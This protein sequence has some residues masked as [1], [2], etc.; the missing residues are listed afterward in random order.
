MHRALV[1]IV[2]FLG[3]AARVDARDPDLVID[4]PQ[5][6]NY[7]YI[8]E[9]YFSPDD[10][11]VEEQCVAG[12]GVRKLLR[13]RT[14]S[15]N[16]GRVDLVMGAPEGNPLF[17][18]SAC[19]GH[20]HFSDY[21]DYRLK[22]SMG[23]V[24]APGHKQAFCLE[25][26]FQYLFDPWVG[27]VRLYACDS[28]GIQAGWSDVYGADLDCQWVDVTGVPNGTYFL[29]V[30]VNPSQVLVEEDLTNNIA[31]VQ[32]QITDVVGVSHRPDGWI[33]PGTQLRVGRN[34]D[35]DRL[36]Y[37]VATCPAQ[38]YVALYSTGPVSA[39][40]Y[41]GA[42]CALGLA[43]DTSV[44]IPDP[45]PGELV[46]L[47]VVGV[48]SSVLPGAEGGHG[49]DSSGRPRPSSGVGLCGITETRPRTY[50]TD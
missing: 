23:T 15:A 28:Q 13:F 3:V 32:V 40:G 16:I 38:D 48:D 12:T 31:T 19:H 14:T 18:F 5:L 41:D 30:E 25:D 33:V 34:G 11:A 50:C 49:F 10:C 6:A 22:D 47:T 17:E 39:Y 4:E 43:G 45:A 37:D 7:W 46:W 36:Q 35:L 27:P 20:Y 9:Q 42:V 24:V 1:V 2:L 8:D 21:A 26:S 44:A 29:E